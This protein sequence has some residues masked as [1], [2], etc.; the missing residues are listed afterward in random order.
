MIN[1]TDI[2]AAF[3]MLKKINIA[4]L[5]ATE[6]TAELDSATRTKDD[7][8]VR[9]FLSMR[10]EEINKLLEYERFLKK[11]CELMAKED[12]VIFE[13]IINA[14]QCKE[15]SANDLFEQAKRNKNLLLKLQASDKM[16]NKRVGGKKSIFSKVD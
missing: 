14:V 12:A 4:L 15:P 6:L 2:D 3:E 1:K 9:M 5:E 11:Q 10:R 7:V 8:T 16:M 13:D